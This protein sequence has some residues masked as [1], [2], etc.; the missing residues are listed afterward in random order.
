M[1][2]PQD[3]VIA[4]AK[5]KALDVGMRLSQVGEA[6]VESR[7]GILCCG[8]EIL[9]PGLGFSLSRRAF[10]F[11]GVAF[12]LGLLP[13]VVGVGLRPGAGFLLGVGLPVLGRGLILR[14]E[15]CRLKF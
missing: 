7:R 2:R 11:D 14:G 4:N 8:A 15:A 9:G 6:P 10:W 3:L 1:L 13:V 12:S 5:G